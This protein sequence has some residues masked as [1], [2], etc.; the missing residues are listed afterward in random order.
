MI[1]FNTEPYND[2]FDE[3]NKFY[4]ILFR[5]SFAVQAR[6]LTQLQ[7]IL[8]NQIQRHGDFVF[9]QGAMVIPGQ[10]SVETIVDTNKGSD[11][12][13]LQ[14]IYNGVAVE[15]F[16]DALKGKVIQGSSGLK[17]QVYYVQH[18]E[19]TEPTTIYVRYQDS[20][21][22]GTVKT[23]SA[24]EV[25]TTEDGT[26]S[27]QAATT[28]A[29]GKGSLATIG[30]GVYYVNGHFCLVEE[31]TIVL[32][33]YT[34]EPTYRVGLLATEVIVTPEDNETLLDNAQNSYN[35][36]APGAHRY[37][38]DLTLTKLSIDS[39]SDLDFVELIRVVDG[40]KKTIVESTDLNELGKILARRTYDES[41]DY[42]VREFPI[43]IREYRDN[44]RGAWAKSTV[45]LVGDVITSSGKTY[46]A[47]NS[48]TSTSI[49]NSNPTHTSG[50]AIDGTNGIWWEYNEKPFYNR[51]INK[52]P[53]QTAVT[54]EDIATQRSNE[55]KLAIGLE[56]GKAY[57]QGY[58]IEKDS[59]TYVTVNKSRDYLQQS[60]AVVPATVGNYV[61]VTNV[62]NAPPIETLDRV[63]LYNRVTGSS[64]RGSVP[65][66]AA[67]V[68]YARARYMEW[69]DIQPFGNSSI[70]KLGLFD[71]QMNNG[72][73]FARDVK[74]FYAASST[75]SPSGDANLAFTADISPQTLSTN[76]LDGTVTASGTTVTGTGTAFTSQLKI[77]DYINVA[78]SVYRVSAIASANSLTLDTSL[79][80]TG[81]T[82]TRAETELK[83]PNNSALIFALPFSS[84][85]SVRKNGDPNTNYWPE[86]ASS[87]TIDVA[88]QVYQKFTQTASG[89]TLTL[90]TS[91]TFASAAETDNY[92]CIDN[93]VTTGGAIF[94][95]TSITV[96]GSTCTIDVTGYSGKSIT[97]IAAVI[98]NGAEKTKT[99]TPYT[100]IQSYNVFKT[101]QE[102]QQS[103]ILLEHADIF[104]IKSVKM[105]PGIAFGSTPTYAQY[106]VDIT[107]RYEFDNGQ[108]ATH[109]DLGRLTLKQSYTVPSNPIIVEYEYFD[110]GTGDYFSINSY[111]NAATG[112]NIPDYKDI[113]V[114]LR[115][116]LDFRP[117]V[118][119]KSISATRTFLGTGSSIGGVPKRGVDITAY[120]TYYIGRKDKI[121]LDFN[122]KFSP[123]TGV[124]SLTPGEPDT[125]ALGM[126]CYNL[127]YQPY[128]FDTSKDSV[129]AEKVEN[130][131]YTMRDIGKLE[132]R[133]DNLEYYTSLSLL[134]TETQ[135]LKIPDADTGMDRMKNGFIVDNFTSTKLAD[136]S[137]QD[138]VCSID[139]QAGELR[140]YYTM[141]NAA[142]LEK[143]TLD[144]QRTS[145]GY[146]LSGDII[147]LPIIDN[148]VLVK[149]EY[150]SRLENI[151]PFAIFTFLGNVTLNPA[152]DDWFET[153][154]LPDLIQDKEGNYNSVRDAA[155]KAGQIGQNGLGTVWSAW[156]TEWLGK[157]VTQNV[158]FSNTTG[159]K[160][161]TSSASGQTLQIDIGSGG[162]GGALRRVGVE[163][164]A[165]EVGQSRFGIQ[166][167]LV[168]KVDYETVGDRVL[169]TAV[170]PYIRSRNVLVQSKGLK[171][172]TRFYPY[173]DDVDISSFIT[174]AVRLK[175]TTVSGTFDDSKNVGGNTSET[176]RRINGDA[177]VCLNK[178]DVITNNNGTAWAVV[179]G[180]SQDTSGNKY[181]DLANVN[182]DFS[183]LISG[184]A[185]TITGSISGAIGTVVNVTTPT[186]LVTNDNGDLNFVFNIPNTDA[187]HFRTGSRELK[188]IDASTA[189]GQWT[190]R[191]RAVYH[192]E[193][194]LE[195]KQTTINAVRN[196]EL[197]REMITD[198]KTVW[199]T[200]ARIVSDTGWYDPL[201]QS[202]L[203]QQKGGAFLTKIDVFFATKDDKMPVTLE[204]REMVNGYP[205]K[206]VLPFSRVSLKPEQIVLSTTNVTIDGTDYPSYDTPTTFTF[207]TPV[208][209][210][211]NQEYC[212]VLSSDSNNYHVW[213]S[214]MGDTIPGAAGRTISQQP[215]NG[216]M[217]KS[218]NAS[219]WTAEQNQDIKFTI[220]RAKFDTSVTGTVDFV[221]NL[222][223]YQ[224]IETDPFQTVSGTNT[225][226]VWHWDHGMT[227]GSKVNI[228]GVSAAVNGIPAAELMGEKTIT[229]IDMNS[230]T[231][232]TVTNATSTGY[233]G[234]S[235]V[236]ATRNIQYDVIMPSVEMQNFSDTTTTFGVKTTS[237][238]SVDGGQTAYNVDSY[239]TP[240]LNKENNYFSSPRMI[241]SE[242]NE[243]TF[244]AGAD[245]V[246]FTVGMKSTNDSLSPVIDTARASLVAI[247]NK[248]N[249]PT[250]TNINVAALDLK[251]MFTG[252]TGAFS[253]GNIGSLWVASS[254]GI[255]VGSQYY[256]ENRLY[257]VV[258]AGAFGG[259][260]PIHTY[261]R[262]INGTTIL[263]YAG[264]P[265]VI[266]STNSSVRALMPNLAV[267]KYI[268]V[269]GTT[270]NNGTFLVTGYTDDGTTGKVVLNVLATTE[271]S[272]SGSTV[273]LREL[274][275][276][277]IAPNG[278]STYS[279][280]VTTPI[281]LNLSSTFA[282]IRFAANVPNGADLQLYYKTCVGDSKQL[283]TTK[284][285]LATPK[286]TNG[287]PKVEL[288]DETFYD[289]DFDLENMSPFNNIVVKLV[290]KSTNSC[291]VPRVKDLRII[292]C[293]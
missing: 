152:S 36:A 207:P 3:N 68:G 44:N 131:R 83:E 13:K 123:I 155:L 244:M 211:D 186:T 291:L 133:I 4:R 148:P 286:N 205:G 26:Y 271:N 157:P 193:G 204:I 6:E 236:Q 33:K 265:G 281:K 278:S 254:T 257:T 110:H 17:A 107:D 260:A 45:Y 206:N 62:N 197:V 59:T 23:F 101:Q 273:V 221:N 135:S 132:K 60:A 165:Q 256:Y 103:I 228:K 125:P 66:G 24:N 232:T 80:A 111:K 184:S 117:K 120:F 198:S 136:T 92:I 31:Q 48:G 277:E 263:E 49:D 283:S 203:V 69:H 5:P 178:G 230:Y 240:C 14:P 242:L 177:Q 191:G 172:N 223:P 12:V 272:V 142:L 35:F 227:D 104:R 239:S 29:T 50:V 150:A 141:Y 167:S 90:S 72:Y 253:F 284:Y 179:I 287:I 75:S 127:T 180:K 47:K 89:T 188:L 217:F 51:G 231:F 163:I 100:G 251:T 212:F 105:A 65:S 266:T 209:V 248:V 208:Y 2:D 222:L 91:G 293:A 27:F 115:D 169:S 52:P 160:N 218:Q 159:V 9:K 114:F 61:L 73:D 81:A 173:F 196:A 78:G 215:Y 102:A 98:K 94:K 262:A 226:R 88:Y 143:N 99:L 147:T 233:G 41:G 128:T 53:A 237:G 40:K 238:K 149:Q 67:I 264:N 166:T 279:K 19:N 20:G 249:A 34:N 16:V 247:N 189:T 234:G 161:V 199:N 76:I 250:E 7:T 108:R 153:N 106:T 28:D 190:S 200:D 171:P 183:T 235:A 134:E 151:N 43:D 39:T 275:V 121:V 187:A 37:S 288:G 85:R 109:Y 137:A 87:G 82:F 285:T 138:H 84:I 126:V 42:T 86:L 261:G 252:A 32:D 162:G 268:T 46:V 216:V 164:T 119:N 93:D 259:A 194:V 192:A 289:V 246:T 292:A 96:S 130:K 22:S 168:Q 176:K 195:T 116:S 202:F 220:Y 185:Q 74:S 182:G 145:S 63:A 77:G 55:A 25:I 213:I 54:A 57:V 258:Q 282:R 270:N 158:T 174:P 280:Y 269:S 290:M 15:T 118:A 144:A 224:T 64:G 139:M 30:R 97:V 18:L 210:Q 1:D 8:Q 219:T 267:G 79:T 122:G 156:Q 255:T 58:E 225:V 154:R 170:I 201:A 112:S 21:T 95:P 243:N 124:P 175:Y 113:P 38:I 274:F 146:K 71:I 140:P 241:A 70:Y 181:L 229:N 129:R 10:A 245:S 56:A 11:Y 276:D 214:N